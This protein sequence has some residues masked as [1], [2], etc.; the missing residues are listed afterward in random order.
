MNPLSQLETLIPLY[1]KWTHSAD[2]ED[3]IELNSTINQLNRMDIL[4]YFIQQQSA[5]STEGHMEHSSRQTTFYILDHK[6]N[7][8][9]Y[10]FFGCVGSL[11][12]RAGFL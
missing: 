5:Q 1:Q 6:T 3:T 10:C 11:L 9:L 8:F 12:L 4:D 2:S 7:F